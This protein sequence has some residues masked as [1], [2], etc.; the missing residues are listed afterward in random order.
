MSSIKIVQLLLCE[1]VFDLDSGLDW[2]K[3]TVR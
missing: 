2:G 3:A 1:F